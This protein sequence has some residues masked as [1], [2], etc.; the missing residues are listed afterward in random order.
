MVDLDG[1]VATHDKISSMGQP[2]IQTNIKIQQISCKYR[3]ITKQ[4][5]KSKVVLFLLY[6]SKVLMLNSTIDNRA[7]KAHMC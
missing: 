5:S 6:K 2:A 3:V 1:E 7:W 4:L